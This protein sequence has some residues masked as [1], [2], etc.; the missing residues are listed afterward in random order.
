MC[1]RRL[2]SAVLPVKRN[3]L[4]FRAAFVHLA[5][6][7]D[8]VDLRLRLVLRGSLSRHCRGVDAWFAVTRHFWRNIADFG[9]QALRAGSTAGGLLPR[10]WALIDGSSR[11]LLVGFERE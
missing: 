10:V 7:S 2:T 11:H 1:G 9:A 5:A 6:R 4:D 3:K 8:P